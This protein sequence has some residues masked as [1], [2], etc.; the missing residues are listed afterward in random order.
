MDLQ[1][2]TRCWLYTKALIFE[3]PSRR[4]GLW[5]VYKAWSDKEYKLVSQSRWANVVST[6]RDSAR[7]FQGFKPL[8]S[9]ALV[10]PGI[11]VPYGEQAYLSLILCPDEV[12][13]TCSNVVKVRVRSMICSMW[14]RAGLYSRQAHQAVFALK[15]NGGK[16]Q[17][18]MKAW[19]SVPRVTR[20]WLVQGRA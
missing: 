8:N 6:W 11:Q 12:L 9:S 18:I 17:A 14:N 1:W 10:S 20:L 5:D 4:L 19:F 16:S 15:K 3:T 2:Y 7:Y 13:Q